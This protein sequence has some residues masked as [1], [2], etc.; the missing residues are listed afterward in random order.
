MDVT[1]LPKGELLGISIAAPV[2]P[3]GLLTIRRTLTGGFRMGIATGLGAATADASN[4]VIAAFGLT[5]ITTTLVTNV[6]LI[7]LVGGV[8]LLSIGL[9]GMLHARH[10]SIT[11]TAAARRAST[12]GAYLQTIGLTLSNP[13]TVISFI[14]VFAGLGITGGQDDLA[15]AVALVVGVGLGS[16][17]WWF[18]LCGIISR[19]RTRLSSGAVSAINLGSS[20]IITGFGVAALIAAR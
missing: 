12:L 17:A 14:G 2:G 3:I 16:A 4:G 7:R 1:V 15:S 5:A 11:E 6:T 8:M 13:L 20:L 19:L 9:R 18:L 10:S